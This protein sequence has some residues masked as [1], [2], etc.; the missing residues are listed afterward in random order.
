[1]NG[2]VVGCV[3]RA[4]ECVVLSHFCT[5]GRRRRRQPKHT[6]HSCPSASRAACSTSSCCRKLERQRGVGG[7]CTFALQNRTPSTHTPHHYTNKQKN[8]TKTKKTAT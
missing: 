2:R 4:R 1:M 8:K 5:F 3:C 7:A 6:R